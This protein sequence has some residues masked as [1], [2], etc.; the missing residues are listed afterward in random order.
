MPDV[1]S[2]V[3]VTGA[4][5]QLGRAIVERFG[6]SA[7]VHALGR[8]DLDITDASAVAD[9]FART[10]PT[11]V[12]NC[13]AF[14]DVDGA[15]DRP[16]EAIAVNGLATGILARAAGACGAMLVHFSTDF[17]FAGRE[18]RAWTEADLPEPQCVYAQSKL[19]GEW[20]ARDCRRHLVL[21]VESLFGGP[22]R[23][24]TIDRIA[25]GLREG[26]EMKLF[27]N[28]TVTPSFVDDVAEA[29]RALVASGAP[30][31]VYHCVNSGATTW[32][33]MGR[34]I[35]HT[36][37]LDERLLVPVSVADVRM[38]A[39]RPQYAALSNQK[40]AQAGVPMPAWED[41]L[42]RYLARLPA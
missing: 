41:A 2:K 17:V 20:L 25:A 1:S 27:H 8:R 35:A 6:A 29:T 18:D 39:A 34:H 9:L 36:L 42:E 10:A 13:A 31:G 37:G 19:V 28:R 5:G 4:E 26:R 3:V 11:L 40:L 7:A 30:S 22:Q 33:G 14:T 16:S 24:S 23:R 15:E 21:R 32:L 38:K 12:V